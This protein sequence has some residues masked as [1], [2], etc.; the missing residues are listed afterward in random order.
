MTEQKEKL[1]KFCKD[2][3]KENT[4]VTA[5]GKAIEESQ[6]KKR[7][8]IIENFQKAI[9]DIH[10]KLEQ[11][12]E[13]R[14]QT[15]KENEILKNQ[16]ETILK[17]YELREQQFETEL[18]KADLE[19]QLIIARVKE[20]VEG[21]SHELAKV[22]VLE[23]QLESKAKVEADLRK[24]LADYS[25]KFTDIQKTIKSSNKSFK[26][27][28][29]DLTTMN[30]RIQNLER[31]KH[32]LKNDVQQE[33]LKALQME[34]KYLETQKELDNT[35]N[36]RDKLKGLCKSLDADRKQLQDEVNTLRPSPT[37]SEESTNNIDSETQETEEIVT[38]SA[39][40]D[41]S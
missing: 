37:V 27:V 10:V 2:L 21:I 32:E 24:K 17:Q 33:K 23:K 29:K 12:A 25:K 38:Q 36:Q 28:T 7:Q 4:L 20:Q 40:T 35:A 30:E 19:K 41:Q 9:G 5:N 16:V 1:Q 13:A 18:K 11:E 22:P 26:K 14:F 31:E 6:E 34:K 39:S 3:H 15:M 8:E